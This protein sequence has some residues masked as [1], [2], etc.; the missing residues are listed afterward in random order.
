MLGLLTN[1]VLVD[2]NKDML[3]LKEELKSVIG[4]KRKYLLLRIC[5]IEPLAARNMV[6]VALGTY[7]NWLLDQN[8]LAVHRRIDELSVEHKK[9]AINMLRRDNQLS[10]VLLE[11]QMLTKMKAE[12]DSGEYDLLK[13]P[14]AKE[15]YSKLMS[16]LDVP[17]PAPTVQNLTWEQRIEQLNITK[18]LPQQNM[19]GFIEGEIVEH[20]GNSETADIQEAEFTESQAGKEV[21]TIQEEPQKLVVGSA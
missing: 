11:G 18:E 1:Y 6:G 10:A 16:D 19:A 12:I 2:Y 4:N 15:V 7:N 9:E 17:T 21:S 8:F 20:E 14:I 13:L 3:T 5:N